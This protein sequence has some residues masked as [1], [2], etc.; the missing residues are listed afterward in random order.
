MKSEFAGVLAVLG[1][2][3]ILLFSCADNSLPEFP[4]F[5]GESEVSSSSLN[6]ESSSSLSEAS[7]SSLATYTLACAAV[8]STGIAGIA[9]IPPVVTCNGMVVKIG[10]DWEGE[11]NWSNPVVGTY[12]GISVLSSYG[13]CYGKTTSCSGT[14]TVEAPPSADE[15]T[16]IG[17]PATGVFGTAVTQPTVRCGLNTVATDIT[18]GDAPAWANPAAATYDVSATAACGGSIK[19]ANCGKL[20]VASA[21][22]CT[23]LTTTGTAGSAITQPT[24]T[25]NGATVPGSILNWTGAPNWNDPVAG[26]YSSISVSA[27]YGECSGKTIACSGTLTVSSVLTCSAVPSTGIAGITITPPVVTCNGTAVPSSILNWAGAPNW[28]NPVESTHNNISVSVSYGE[29]NGKTASCSGTLTVEA[30]P[31]ADELTCTGMPATGVFGTAITQPTVRCG[32]NTVATGISWENAPAW[33]N[34]AASTYNVSATASCWGKQQTA[35]CGTLTVASVLACSNVPTSGTAGTAITAPT[36]T[37]NGATISSGFNWAGAP[38]WNNPA[39]G[40]YNNVSVSASSGDCNGITATCNGTLTVAS[41]YTITYNA[42]IGVTGVALPANQTKNYNVVLT[43]SAA[44]PTRIGY[45][46][47]SWSTSANGAGMSYAPG[48]SYTDNADLTLYAQWTANTYT[49][50]YNANNGIGV[51]ANQMKTHDIALTLSAIVPTRTGHTF[52]GWNTSADGSGTP[53]TS[54]ANYTDNAGVTLYAQ[55]TINTYT[56]TFNANGGTNGATTSQTKTHDVALT[57]TND[58]P[59]RTGYTFA[60]WNTAQSGTGTTYASGASYTDNVGVTLYAQWTANT[61]TII[62]NVNNGIGV[63]DNQTKIYDVALTLSDDV[64]TRTGFTFVGWNTSADGSGTSY[65]S[66][67]SYTSNAGV[68]LYAQWNSPLVPNCN[69]QVFQSV[70]IGT[71]TWMAENLNC[72]VGGSQCYGNSEYYCDT[73]GRLYDWA[74]A[75]NLPTS[76]NS[77]TCASQV[78]TKHRGI[79]PSGWHIPSSADWNVL[80]KFVNPSCYDNSSCAGAGTKLKATSGWGSNGNGQDT[81]GFS[82]LPGGSGYSDGSFSD[83]GDCGYWWSSSESNANYAYARGMYSSNEGAYYYSINK[84]DLFSV[85]CLQD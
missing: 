9:I 45:T 15:L 22:A 41:T 28:N 37:C 80:M 54:G 82:A 79:C 40:T 65:A 14:L 27:S 18:W 76:C 16:C 75:M 49:I 71:Q 69:S 61:Y 39:A 85:R 38:N 24:V 77:S 74:T 56:I 58:K 78:G 51:I 73:Y 33:A 70:N 30:A 43:L 5:V 47:A 48:A 8:P 36:V 62:Y 13:E 52:A 6:E 11:P 53:Y 35:S 50:I 55:W 46:F 10:L 67:A 19:T 4:K 60:S 17:M 72:N 42:G 81:Y 83:V 3:A 1:F 2:C 59:T 66:G 64:P 29:C 34:P 26:T 7:S 84:D 31:S 21:L 57:L 32:P 63:P 23:N 68:T 20:T 12:S 44:I 25:C